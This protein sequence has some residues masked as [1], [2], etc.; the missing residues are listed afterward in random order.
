MCSSERS[1]RAGSAS[2]VSLTDGMYA[3]AAEQ[4]TK[5]SSQL[6]ADPM[7]VWCSAVDGLH[8]LVTHET[9]HLLQSLRN[10]ARG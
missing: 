3:A 6:A 10:H 7:M 1:W 2:D 9:W 5:V 8:W 4:G